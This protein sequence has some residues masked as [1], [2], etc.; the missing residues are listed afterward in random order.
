MAV[1]KKYFFISY[2]KICT[3]FEKMVC[4]IY[5]LSGRFLSFWGKKK[6]FGEGGGN[7]LYLFISRHDSMHPFLLVI[8]IIIGSLWNF[9]CSFDFFKKHT[10]SNED[11]TL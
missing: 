9:F 3:I 4:Y 10:K 2:R 11:E 6:Y 8:I 7:P 1:Y 5:F